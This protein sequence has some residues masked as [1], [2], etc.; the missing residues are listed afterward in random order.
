M[1]SP[2]RPLCD[3]QCDPRILGPPRFLVP[4]S[5]NDKNS[6]QL[7]TDPFLDAYQ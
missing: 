6:S 5:R 7:D 1:G 4:S 2:Y 3:V